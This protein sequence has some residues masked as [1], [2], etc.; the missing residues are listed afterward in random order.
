MYMGNWKSKL[1]AFLELNDQDILSSAGR[2]SNEMARE[3]AHAEYDR[4]SNKQHQIEA[5][6][7]DEDLREAVKK[8]IGKESTNESNQN[9]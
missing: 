5:N 4:Y 3:L 9:R 1:D 8:L 7:V 2:I 6:K